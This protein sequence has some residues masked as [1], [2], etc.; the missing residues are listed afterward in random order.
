MADLTSARAAK[1]RLCSD[2]SGHTGIRGVGV[3]RQPDGYCIQVNLDQSAADDIP[4]AVDGVPVRVRIVG[5]I[6]AHA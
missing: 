2:L 1:A 3:S 6:R 5:A 4:R